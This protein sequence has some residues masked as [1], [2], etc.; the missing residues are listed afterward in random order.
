LE[1]HLQ[2]TVVIIYDCNLF[3][4]QATH[5]PILCLQILNFGK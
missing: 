4:I 1:H 3:I 5:E 2:T